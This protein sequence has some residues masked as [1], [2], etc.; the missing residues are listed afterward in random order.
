MRGLGPQRSG[1]LFRL[2]AL[3]VLMVF[4]ATPACARAAPTPAGRKVYFPVVVR[5]LA[6]QNGDFE[7][8]PAAWRN[9][10]IP[11][12]PLIFSKA[13]LWGIPPHSGNWAA[14]LGGSWEEMAVLTQ[15]ISI[16]PGATTLVYW[17][18][19]LSEETDCNVDYSRVLV[20]GQ[21]LR[22]EPLCSTQNTGGWVQT[23][24]DLSAYTGSTI[25]L[26][27]STYTNASGNSNLYLDDISLQAT[28]P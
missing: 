1:A 23:S 27:L 28:A 12:Y 15:T 8:G 10:S 18:W 24:I 2:A 9:D 7:S 4:T 14:W 5:P 6:L 20:N 11:L 3:I 26:Q 19:I 21:V 17:H 16:L 13:D 22:R 25:T